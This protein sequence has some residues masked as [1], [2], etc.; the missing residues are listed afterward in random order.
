M[1]SVYLFTSRRSTT[2]Q[3]HFLLRVSDLR[4]YFYFVLLNFFF[5]CLVILLPVCHQSLQKDEQLQIF[6]AVC[7]ARRFQS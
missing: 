4:L 1:F 6:P 5:V 3:R 7:S 2:T